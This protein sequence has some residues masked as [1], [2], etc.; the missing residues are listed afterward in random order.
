MAHRIIW[1]MFVGDIPSNMQ[2]D[3]RDRNPFNNRMDNLRLVTCAQNQWNRKPCRKKS[4]LP[5]GVHSEYG[6]Y[7][8][9]IQHLGKAIR[10]GTFDSP[11]EASRAYQEMA[12]KLRPGF[13]RA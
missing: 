6:K 3:H 13:F 2:V 10:L 1:V 5:M 11:D 9:S 4:S 7:G 8:A 12:A